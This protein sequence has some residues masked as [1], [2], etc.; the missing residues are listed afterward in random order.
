MNRTIWH[1]AFLGAVLCTNTPLESEA[2]EKSLLEKDSNGSRI[3][4]TF[5]TGLLR[6]SSD[7]CEQQQLAEEL[8]AGIEQHSDDIDFWQ[9][10]VS[11]CNSSDYSLAASIAL[12]YS[13]IFWNAKEAV[14]ENAVAA[15]KTFFALIRT[16]IALRLPTEESELIDL[17]AEISWRCKIKDFNLISDL[18]ILKLPASSR[19]ILNKAASILAGEHWSFEFG[20]AQIWR[21]KGSPMIQYTLR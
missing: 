20:E 14:I 5:A 15:G 19:K 18:P 8:I 4:N 6:Q 2:V 16:E 10:L 9:N 13:N 17:L 1:E 21:Y 12:A 3:W 7:S 11:R